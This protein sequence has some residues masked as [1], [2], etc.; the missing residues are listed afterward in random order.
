MRKRDLKACLRQRVL[1]TLSVLLTIVSL[2]ALYRGYFHEPPQPRLDASG[3]GIATEALTDRLLIVLGD[4][5]RKAPML[6]PDGKW[7][8]SGYYIR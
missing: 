3:S 2:L 8:V 6:D 5:V 1:L 7:R 4:S